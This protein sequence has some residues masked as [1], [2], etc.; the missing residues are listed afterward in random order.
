MQLTT[1]EKIIISFLI[2]F[3]LW[4]I[5]A[6]I[7][8]YKNDSTQITNTTVKWYF[9][10]LCIFIIFMIALIYINASLRRYE[11]LS[12]VTYVSEGKTYNEWKKNKR[13][14]K[15]SRRSRR[16]DEDSSSDEDLSLLND[17]IIENDEVTVGDNNVIIEADDIIFKIPP[18]K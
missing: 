18:E 17:E 7:Y 8:F 1:L 12:T 15:V 13:D 5:I 6:Y 3:V 4:T 16:F 10:A 9:T 14:K 11:P 2:L